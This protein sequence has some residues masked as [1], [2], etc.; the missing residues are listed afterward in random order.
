MKK[1]LHNFLASCS[2]ITFFNAITSPLWVGER[3]RLVGLADS[4][5]IGELCGDKKREQP[6]PA[7]APA[8]GPG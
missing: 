5:A 2:G 6:G 1:Y 4:D 8:A 7:C 3:L